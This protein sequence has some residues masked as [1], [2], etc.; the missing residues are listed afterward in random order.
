MKKK[1]IS[2][3]L[4][5]CML[6]SFMPIIASAATSG[7]CGK[8]VTWTLDD[9]GILTISGTGEMENAPWKSNCDS[10][11]NVIIEKGVTS[12]GRCAFEKCSSDKGNN[13]KQRN[14]YRILCFW[15]M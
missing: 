5:L 9:N 10:I 11:K 15:R 12:I 2:L 14:K 13:S 8:N 4:V 6:L 7:T 3:T 1:V